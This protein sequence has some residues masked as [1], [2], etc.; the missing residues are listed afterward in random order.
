MRGG[1]GRGR[2]DEEALDVKVD[3]QVVKRITPYI[4]PYVPHLLAG[5]FFML[6]V[7][8]TGLIQP[9]LMRRAIDTYITQNKDIAGLT[10][11]S[12]VY[13]AVYVLNW[14]CTYWQTYFV[15]WAGQNI[16]FNIR[17]NLFEHLQ[18]LSFNFY[19]R[20]EVG[21]IMS[22]VT[23]DVNALS[24]LVSSGI[25]NVINDVFRLVGIIGIMLSLNWRLAL[26]T[27]TTLPF[28][29][30]L[31]TKFRWR[32]RRAYH[33]VRRKI[34]TVNANLQESIS[35]IRVVQ[36]FTREDTNAARFDATN[37]ENM[38]ANMQAAQLH[39]MFGPLVDLVG[40]VGV[41]M[42]LW[43]GGN[44]VRTGILTVGTVY[45]FI[46]YVNQ[47][48]MP[49]RDLAQVYNTW[50]SATVS[51]D[52]I[53]EVL[54]TEPEVQDAPGAY[55]LPP[56]DGRVVFDDVTFGYYPERP[57]LHDINLI[58]EPG[59]TIALVGPTGAG[60]SSIINLLSRFYDPQEGSITIDGHDLRDVK[61]KSLHDQ[62]GIVLQD[63]FLFSGTIRDNICYG[64]PDAT[65]EE[66]YA[67][68]RAVNA[69][70]FIMRLPDGYNTEVH[71][72]G[73]R[74]SIG[75]R[76]LISFARALICDPR[77]LILDEA[78]SSVDAYTEVIIQ[79]ALDRLLEGRTAFVIAHR[80]S[81]IRN[82]DKIIVIDQGRI[83]EQGTHEE[84]LEKPDG[85]YRLLYE[86]QYKHQEIA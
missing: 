74:L 44:L 82:A 75:Q 12:L 41:A 32:M 46:N 2:F 20:I 66:I 78:T 45:A 53:F 5:M 25:L 15:S 79:Q 43:Y 70:E 67:A 13:L 86:M 61:L 30:L 48:Y 52:R 4:R 22:R 17:Q 24:E 3:V 60:K 49:I 57:I 35:G 9:L 34:A 65:D 51:I 84:L 58:A 63:T 27:F 29:V 38:Q 56:I 23:N 40:V 69:H 72:R 36:S 11:I 28:L 6:A 33:E 21:R 14:L 54:E 55:E 73:A 62:M 16:I 77:I 39:S 71:E 19:D 18:K 31:A 50:Q 81:T 7:S 83:V 80:L 37:A 47:F 42:V 85:L 64:R 68:A 59:Q 10:R 26:L 1:G 76:Q 8:V